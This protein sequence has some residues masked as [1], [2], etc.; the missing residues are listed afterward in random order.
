[1]HAYVATYCDPRRLPKKFYT[2]VYM[3]IFADENNTN[4]DDIIHSVCKAAKS[5]VIEKVYRIARKFGRKLDLA[6]WQYALQLPN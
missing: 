5:T 3:K 4:Y 6:V 2:N 1:M